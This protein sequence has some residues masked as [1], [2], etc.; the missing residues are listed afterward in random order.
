M[1]RNK[2]R[3]KYWR[4]NKARER[5]DKRYVQSIHFITDNTSPEDWPAKPEGVDRRK[6]VAAQGLEPRTYG[7]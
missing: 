4:K 7:L 6:M 3:Q 2:R 5:K 1:K